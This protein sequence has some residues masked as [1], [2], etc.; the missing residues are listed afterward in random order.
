MALPHSVPVP[1]GPDLMHPGTYRRVARL[2]RER[3][4]VTS[5]GLEI[6]PGRLRSLIAIV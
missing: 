3:E 5:E 4:P 6:E 1:L 2:S